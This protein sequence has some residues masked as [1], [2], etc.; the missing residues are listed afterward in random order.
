ML[1]KYK[2]LLKYSG[3]LTFFTRGLNLIPQKGFR[4]FRDQQFFDYPDNREKTGHYRSPYQAQF[5]LSEKERKENDKLPV[6]ERVLDWKKYM[7][8]KGKLKYTT[9][10]YLVD[11]E[12][13]PRLKVMMLC[14]IALSYL[15][16]IPDSHEYKHFSFAWVK[17]IMRVVDENESIID[18][19]S[20][21][22]DIT[23]IE[24]LIMLLN[25]EVLL[26][27]TI[28]RERLWEVIERE[29]KSID[30]KEFFFMSAAFRDMGHPFVGPIDTTKH[31][32]NERPER[33]KTA[34]F[35]ETENH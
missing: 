35:G 14:D 9:G 20:K 2:C 6:E 32:K 16:K 5:T 34:G 3:K 33:P 30:Y 7:K 13:F 1:G 31:K 8:H 11:V 10:V 23:K 19:E 24:D 22:K 27:K 17:Y 25:K 18:I 15:R 12:P 4:D 28:V 29:V 26:L 21:L